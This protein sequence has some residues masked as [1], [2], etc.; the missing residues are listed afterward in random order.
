MKQLLAPRGVCVCV[1]VSLQLA[2]YCDGSTAE[3]VGLLEDLLGHHTLS[4]QLLF[5][6]REVK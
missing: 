6:K 5:N 3:L 1:C 4:S 2:P